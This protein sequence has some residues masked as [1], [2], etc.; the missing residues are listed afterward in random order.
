MEQ[1]L[2]LGFTT[3]KCRQQG[4]VNI[5]DFQGECLK[6]YVRYQA[7]EAGKYHVACPLLPQQCHKCCIKSFSVRTSGMVKVKRRNSMSSGAFKGKCV[8]TV[9]DNTDNLSR[10][11][12]LFAL[13]YDSLEIGTVP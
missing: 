7:V 2:T 1:C 8:S 3:G 12:S 5:D 9:A 11:Q 10:K 6:K 13:V 4:R